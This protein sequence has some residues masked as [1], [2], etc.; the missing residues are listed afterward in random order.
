MSDKLPIAIY[1]V[2]E[3]TDL[4]DITSL[5]DS[6]NYKEQTLNVTT[7]DWNVHL[8]Y[9]K[10]S[11]HIK[12]KDFI[13]PIVA[14]GQAIIA[15]DSQLTESMALLFQQNTHH[16]TIYVVVA[17]NAY[18][19]LAEYFDPEF[20]LS[21]LS[22]II[23]KDD[24]VLK[25]SKEA[26]LTN[27]IFG[28]IK[29][30]RQNYNLHENET[31]GNFYQELKTLIDKDI[32]QSYLGFSIDDVKKDSLC[33]AK[34]SFKITKSIDFNQLL[35]ILNGF[36]AILSTLNPIE[37][38]NV[39]KLN[40]Q[41]D[42]D[43]IHNL[44]AFLAYK[45]YQKY[46]NHS[47]SFGF[48]ICHPDFEKYLTADYYIIRNAES[49]YGSNEITNLT[50]FDQICNIV[51]NQD[52]HVESFR[53]FVNKYSALSIESYDANS[54]LLTK[55]RVALHLIADLQ[56]KNERY[57]FIENIWYQID[58]EY[59]KQLNEECSAFIN[60][61]Y[62]SNVMLQWD[63]SFSTENDYNGSY[64]GSSNTLVLDKITQENIEL[65]DLMK[66]DNENL[67]LYHVK[68]GVG[69][70]IRDLCSQIFISA[71]RIKRDKN[72]DLSY[73]KVF[74]DRIKE[75]IGGELYFNQVGNQTNNITIDEFI[76]IFKKKI[77]YVLVIHDPSQKQRTIKEIDKYQSNIAK[78]SISELF[79]KMKGINIPLEIIEV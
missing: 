52:G 14:P 29:F 16:D 65:C 34:S 78:L 64:F 58:K 57:F 15:N 5:L 72:T 8:Y 18:F 60:S 30:F 59:I 10:G 27:G 4:N 24:K 12:W 44:R 53:E 1:M 62:H 41:L 42:K 77:T 68:I 71:Q 46:K 43:L 23:T 13:R 26:S 35:T 20:G 61:S 38:N 21:I 49:I 37:I 51:V 47:E 45:L 28:E 75:K 48:D 33:I 50:N 40:K 79:K 22:R 76:E 31:F 73:V 19:T 69:N 39:R 3:E 7:N 36:G 17:G 2:K 70:T 11:S 32:L 9:Q 67:Y 74:Y 56:Y 6:S 25:S 66:W 63:S 54:V 55:G